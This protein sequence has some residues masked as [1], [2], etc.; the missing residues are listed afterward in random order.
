ML[1]AVKK[2]LEGSHFIEARGFGADSN[3]KNN[4]RWKFCHDQVATVQLCGM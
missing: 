4:E 3:G 1:N 2:M